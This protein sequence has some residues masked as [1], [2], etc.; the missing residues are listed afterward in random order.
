MANRKV[1]NE[2]LLGN[3]LAQEVSENHS[4][5]EIICTYREKA[6]LSQEK[7]A[8]MIHISKGKL[9]HWETNETIPRAHM[10]GR[11]IGAL[12]IPD[13]ELINAVSSAQTQKRLDE[14]NAQA[15][16]R[17][18]SEK[19]QRAKHKHEALLLLGTGVLGFVAGIIIVFITGSYKD[20]VWYFPLAIGAACSGIPFGWRMVF[21]KDSFL[22]RRP[23]SPWEYEEWRRRSAIE[24]I[25]TICFYLFLFFL[26]YLVGFVLFPVI[27]LY[28]A[29]KAGKK[30][31][32][33]RII[34]FIA[35][36]V[37]VLFCGTIAFFIVMSAISG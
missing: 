22:K 30:G 23:M 6:G 12:D 10:V 7:L 18:K 20:T 2:I 29:Y 15:D 36:L 24:K 19:F 37:A 8:E 21:G 11:L 35:F 33:Y 25:I 17:A 26:A 4:V 1:D 32:I 13:E 34:M 16:F 31:T 27:L 3:S 5:G 9:V 28:H 14:N